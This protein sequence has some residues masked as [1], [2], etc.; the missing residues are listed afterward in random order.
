MASNAPALQRGIEIINL[1]SE[2]RDCTPTLIEKELNIP[3][4]S[5]SRLIEALLENNTLE[6]A[7]AGRYLKLGKSLTCQVMRSYEKESLVVAVKPMLRRLSERW[8]V[9]FVVYEYLDEFQLIWRVKDEPEDGIKTR[10]P[11]FSIN[12]L[13]INAQGQLFLSMLSDEQIREYVEKGFAVS[14]TKHTLTTCD[15]LLKRVEQIRRDNY[16]YQERESNL[17]MKQIAVP[18]NIRELDGIYALGCF[19]A[20]DFTE[21]YGLRDSMLFEAGILCEAE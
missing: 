7:H 21:T 13:N 2:R 1:V 6:Y 19:L 18:L 3:K 4:A 8:G 5:C 17:S 14:R 10:P 12:H 15:D 11:G 9:T 20:V 16:A